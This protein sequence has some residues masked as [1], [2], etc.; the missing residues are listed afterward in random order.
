[1]HKGTLSALKY[2]AIALSVVACESGSGGVT[3]PAER[4][5]LS[6]PFEATVDSRFAGQPI[7][8]PRLTVRISASSID[9]RG[10]QD[11]GGEHTS[12]LEIV[13]SEKQSA[14]VVP[15]SRLLTRAVPS[16]RPNLDM[17]CKLKPGVYNIVEPISGQTVGILIVYPDCRM[18]VYTG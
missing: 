3:S 18:E 13:A 9:V 10:D 17:P 14:A 2:A 5:S 15:G 7:T 11:Q 1:M 8:S 16:L 4:A 6:L 12:R